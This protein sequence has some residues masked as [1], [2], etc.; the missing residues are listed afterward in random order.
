MWQRRMARQAG[1]IK[2]LEDAIEPT[3]P[4]EAYIIRGFP[5]KTLRNIAASSML[6][7]MLLPDELDELLETCKVG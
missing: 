7:K 4:E 3:L 6:L 5:P 2:T 1:G